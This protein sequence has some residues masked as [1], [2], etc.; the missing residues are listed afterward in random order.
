MITGVNHIGIAVSSIDEVLKVF[1]DSIGFKVVLEEKDEG[2]GFRTTFITTGNTKIEFLQPTNPE[3]DFAKYIERRG[4]G[5]HHLALET[6]DIEAD[7]EALKQKGIQ[8]AGDKPRTG[9]GGSK[10]IFLDRK[11]TKGLLMQ[12]VQPAK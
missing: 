6:N 11:G 2:R 12:L 3:N 4:E 1:R 10:V 8:P 7:I 9:S 5:V